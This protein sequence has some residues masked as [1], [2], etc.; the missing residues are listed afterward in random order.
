MSRTWQPR[1][2]RTLGCLALAVALLAGCSEPVAEAGIEVQGALLE[3]PTIVYDPPLEVTEAKDTVVVE[4]EG[5]R[6]RPDQPVLLHYRLE[7]ADTGELIDQTFGGLPKT[8]FLTPEDLSLG[9]YQALV[10][11]RVGSRVLLLSPPEEVSGTVAT[12]LVADVLATRAEG[13]A[14]EPRPGL[15]T[16]TEDEQGAPVVTVPEGE[17]PT[18]LE[19]QTLV[20]GTGEQIS[21]TSSIVVQYTMVRWSDGSVVDSTWEAAGPKAFS[22]AETVKGWNEGLPEQTVG[23][24]VLLVAPPV[25]AFGDR[26]GHDL[27]GETL[28]YVVDILAAST[29]KED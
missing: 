29:P 10:G 6:L 11:T 21:D 19:V 16:V 2:P 1:A 23:S 5:G 28:V 3:R 8:Y 25:Y 18:D 14:V 17:P 24:R 15:P 9:L 4:G 27:A 20:R 13:T 26:A 12:V 7:S 22:L